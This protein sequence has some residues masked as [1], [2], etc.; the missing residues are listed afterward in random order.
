MEEEKKFSD[1]E[2]SSNT[3]SF[4]R[5]YGKIYAQACDSQGN[6]PLHRYIGNSYYDSIEK[7]TIKLLIEY[8]ASLATQNNAGETVIHVAAKKC[9]GDRLRSFLHMMSIA[10]INQKD[11]AGM[12]ALDRA[13]LNTW[14]ESNIF[15]EYLVAH[16]ATVLSPEALQ[17]L[18]IHGD[19]YKGK[20]ALVQLA[21]KHNPTLIDSLRTF[22]VTKNVTPLSAA[23]R[24]L[25]NLL[26]IPHT[27]KKIVAFLLEKRASTTLADS[28]GNLPLHHVTNIDKDAAKKTLKIL[29]DYTDV[30]VNTG[31]NKK[32]TAL[33]RLAGRYQENG[34]KFDVQ[35]TN[36]LLEHNANVLLTNEKGETP[37][38]LAVK[39]RGEKM[40]DILLSSCASAANIPDNKGNLSLHLAASGRNAKACAIVDL[41]IS[42]NNINV[43][44]CNKKGHTP[45]HKASK[46]VLKRSYDGYSN[47]NEQRMRCEEIV[48][49]LRINGAASDIKDIEGNTPLDIAR[50]GNST[51]IVD[52]CEEDIKSLSVQLVYHRKLLK[53]SATLLNIDRETIELSPKY[54]KLLEL[55]SEKRAT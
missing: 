43:N 40:V 10:E 37:L 33:H 15:V 28:D 36:L 48:R 11:H 31:N 47:Q 46:G 19:A 50:K 34:Q 16:G 22:G 25:Y 7:D 42:S 49:L 2:I 20:F 54:Q 26:V 32:E 6:T 29:L 51:A 45:L 21:Y 3:R 1:E 41:L 14:Y 38:H 4:L 55:G 23:V 44:A 27:T 5:Q 52:L 30:C 12:T 9:V 35:C 24:G 39:S 8:N 18:D 13:I 17:K 53:R